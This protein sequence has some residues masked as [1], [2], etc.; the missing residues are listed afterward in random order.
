MVSPGFQ[1]LFALLV[2]NV[3][4]FTGA[5]TYYVDQGNGNDSNS[6]ISV[7]LAFAS[8]GEALKVLQAGD[9]LRIIGDYKNPSYNAAYTFG[10]VGDTHLWHG[11]NTLRIAD[12]HGAADA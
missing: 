1:V 2:G 9:E 7:G 3:V 5:T 10:N 12:L 6:G 8:H 11:E 4:K